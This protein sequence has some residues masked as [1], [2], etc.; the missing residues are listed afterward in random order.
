MNTSIRPTSEHLYHMPAVCLAGITLTEEEI[1]KAVQITKGFK[2]QGPTPS[3]I[4]VELRPDVTGLISEFR[5]RD[6]RIVTLITHDCPEAL[7]SR[8][9]GNFQELQREAAVLSQDNVAALADINRCYKSGTIVDLTIYPADNHGL[10]LCFRQSG[11]SDPD[12]VYK[13]LSVM[14]V[15][16]AP[17][18]AKNS[19]GHNQAYTTFTYAPGDSRVAEGCFG[20]LVYDRTQE[21]LVGVTVHDARNSVRLVGYYVKSVNYQPEYGCRVVFQGW[22]D[23]SD[24]EAPP[25]SK[26]GWEKRPLFFGQPIGSLVEPLANPVIDDETAKKILVAAADE[27]GDCAANDT[28]IADSGPDADEPAAPPVIKIGAKTKRTRRSTEEAVAAAK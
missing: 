6:Q 5:A 19:T 22:R 12:R 4:F 9:E 27:S 14:S 13:R 28:P 21:S 8:R 1:L 11:T 20:R 17:P 15:D 3:V 26:T 18:D 7:K 24:P 23:P 16:V 10:E 2:I 25:F